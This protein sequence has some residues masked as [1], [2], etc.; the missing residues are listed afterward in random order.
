MN[1]KDSRTATK[2]IVHLAV[3]A[4]YGELTLMVAINFKPVISFVR[5]DMESRAYHILQRARW[6]TGYN[7]LLPTHKVSCLNPGPDPIWQNW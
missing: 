7:T 4:N 1:R 2:D 3:R 6:C 5:E